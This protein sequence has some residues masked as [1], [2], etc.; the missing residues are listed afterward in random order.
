LVRAAI[1]DELTKIAK[2]SVAKTASLQI[3]QNIDVLKPNLQVV[4]A[5]TTARAS[6]WRREQWHGDDPPSR[7]PN[8]RSSC[9]AVRISY[10]SSSRQGFRKLDWREMLRRVDIGFKALRDSYE[11]VEVAD[12]RVTRLTDARAYRQGRRAARRV[13]RLSLCP[14]CGEQRLVNSRATDRG[15]DMTIDIVEC[16]SCSWRDWSE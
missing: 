6:S 2:P 16:S 15:H 10:Q 13:P 1:L 11:V 14:I 12:T 9:F 3:W 7:S 8:H 4:I 5:P